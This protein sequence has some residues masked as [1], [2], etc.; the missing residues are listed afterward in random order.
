V[1]AA[2]C[3][4]DDDEWLHNSERKKS[5]TFVTFALSSPL[6][7]HPLSHS[8]QSFVIRLLLIYYTYYIIYHIICNYIN[9]IL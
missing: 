5:T 6:F 4:N 3:D 9:N 8:F 2:V 1:C 7:T